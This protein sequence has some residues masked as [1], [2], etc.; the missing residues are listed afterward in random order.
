MKLEQAKK[1]YDE[2]VK[3]LKEK[4]YENTTTFE[5]W[6][7][8]QEIKIDKEKET[9]STKEVVDKIDFVDFIDEELMTIA[10]AIRH[11]NIDYNEFYRRAKR[12][13]ID[14]VKKEKNKSYYK[15]E[16]IEKMAQI[17]D[18]AEVVKEPAKDKKDVDKEVLIQ[19]LKI[20][21]K[22]IEKV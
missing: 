22:I 11:L 10:E 13:K 18:K 16:D 8:L 2:Y 5:E 12:L 1:L 4:G 17:N 19:V 21:E 7:R 9:L 20:L 15:R 6:V 3:K 14:R